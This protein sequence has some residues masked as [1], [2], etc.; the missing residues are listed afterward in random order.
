MAALS[1]PALMADP[2]QF[3]LGYVEFVHRGN[4]PTRIDGLQAAMVP[5][6]GQIGAGLVALFLTLL[7]TLGPWLPAFL[8]LAF[9]ARRRLAPADALPW[10]MLAVAAL[11]MLLAPV[12]R[13]GD[14]TEF[15][16]RAG[17]L[18]VVV[19]AAWTLR[20]AALLAGPSA[21]RLARGQG[22]IAWPAAALLCLAV[23]AVTIGPAKRPAMAWGAAYYGSSVA[24]G[25]MELAPVVLRTAGPGARLAVANQPADS[26]NIDD[27]ARLVALTSVPA[28]LSCP[29]FFIATGGAAGEEA[30]RR[31]AAI[32]RLG[33]AQDLDT[34]R[35]LM[36]EEG[37]THYVVTSPTDLPF[38]AERR[39]ATA[40]SGTYALYTLP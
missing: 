18:L 39:H 27:A 15:R 30:R 34:L 24:P 3:L 35:T 5:V 40:R 21:A 9:L 25:L 31:L 4:P 38:D 1:W 16:H 28:L 29:G 33:T 22:R 37:V 8:V 14:I 7:G 36:R 11:E 10:L 19:V 13:N 12:S 32:Q 2:R 20:W 23:L 17:P 6:I 26:R